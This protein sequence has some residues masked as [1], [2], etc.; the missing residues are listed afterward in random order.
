MSQTQG[1][2]QNQGCKLQG[3]KK[4]AV[5]SGHLGGLRRPR[6]GMEVTPMSPSAVLLR[7][8]FIVIPASLPRP[9]IFPSSPLCQFPLSLPVF[10]KCQLG[11]SLADGEVTLLCVREPK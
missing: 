7:F 8:Y 5:G 4:E 11:F 10:T 6:S 1:M 9:A 3:P 2:R